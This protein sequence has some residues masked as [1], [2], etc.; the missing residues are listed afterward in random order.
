MRILKLLTF[1]LIT[2]F[3]TALASGGLATN[4]G[5]LFVSSERTDSL[6]IVDPETSRIIKYLKTS[7][8][9]RDMHFNKDHTYLYVACADD[10][11]IDIIDVAKLEVVGKLFAAKPRAF[12]I[13]ENQ[14]RIYVPNPEGSSLSVIDMNQNVIIQE[15]PTSGGPE[16]VF[17]SEDG[18]FVYV[19]SEVDDFIHL[20]DADKGYVVESVVVGTRPRRFAATPDSKELWVS[21]ELS[22]EVYII[23]RENF[24]IAGKIEFLPPDVRKS[25]VTPIDLAI[26]KDGKTAYVTLG[27]AARVAVVDVQ[28]RKVRGYMPI[29]LRSS[30]V[31]MTGDEETLYVADSFSDAIHVLDLKRHKL[32]GSIP[33]DRRPSGVVIDDSP[34]TPARARGIGRVLRHFLR[35]SVPAFAGTA[36]N[37]L[38]REERDPLQDHAR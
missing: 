28:T 10:D 14:R 16:E 25:D 1:G 3:L 18:H 27:Q 32:T 5:L 2:A 30:G 9:P 38:V 35:T 22:G 13:N 8:R 26:T 17:V 19:A 15:V 7:R 37:R 29:G 20:V 6:V 23:G 33:L 11:A 34:A 4:T 12:G 31:A 36:D 21:S 24:T